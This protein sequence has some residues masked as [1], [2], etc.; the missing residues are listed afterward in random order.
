MR[1][2]LIPD[3]PRVQADNGGTAVLAPGWIH[4]R[5]NLTSSVLILGLRGTVPLE[6]DGEGLDLVPGRAVL[7]P[8]GRDH[9]GTAPLT[10][11]ASYHWMHFTLPGDPP[12]LSQDEADTILSS[13]GVTSHRLDEAALVPLS[14]DLPEAGPFREAF[15]EVLILQEKPAYTGWKFQL[16]FQNLLIGL[17]EEVIGAHR[18]PGDLSPSSSVVYGILARIAEGLTDPNLSI[19]SIAA[20]L[21]LNLDYAGRRFKKVMGLSV[22]EYLLKQRLQQAVVRLRQ[23]SDTL[24][25]VAEAC[26]FGST[27]HFLRQFKASYGRTPTEERARYRRMHFNVV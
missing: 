14:F 11:P 12:L 21:G 26:G 22:G 15:R 16:L 23:T 24:P 25:A 1:H 3:L 5:R 20:D 7:L 8:S 4:P 6:I 18:P 10:E 2:V 27:R 9:G 19:K 13:Q 17:T